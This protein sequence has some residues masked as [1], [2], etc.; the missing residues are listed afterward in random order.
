MIFTVSLILSFLF[1]TQRSTGVYLRV[2]GY[3][4]FLI[5]SLLIGRFSEWQFTRENIIHSLASFWFGLIPA[6]FLY[7]VGVVF[8]GGY[9]CMGGFGWGIG[10]GLWFLALFMTLAVYA[11]YTT[12]KDAVDSGNLIEEDLYPDSGGDS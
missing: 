6:D 2:E 1:F 3:V 12:R 9:S 10:D 5:I 11:G 8:R 7:G 4:L